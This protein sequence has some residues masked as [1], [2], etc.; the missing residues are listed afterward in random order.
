MST[1]T[2][3]IVTIV[4]A[5]LGATAA[6]LTFIAAIYAKA[7]RDAYRDIRQPKGRALTPGWATFLTDQQAAEFRERFKAQNAAGQIA[8]LR[9]A[10]GQGR[11]DEAADHPVRCVACGRL[12]G[13]PTDPCPV[14]P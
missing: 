14:C 13:M 6:V 3:A 9:E 10:Y 8:R 7:A 5:V 12:A 11:D 4:M 1:L 2:A